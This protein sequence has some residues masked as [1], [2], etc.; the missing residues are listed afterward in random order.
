M[1][2]ESALERHSKKLANRERDLRRRASRPE[3]EILRSLSEL[4]QESLDSLASEAR[5]AIQI[6]VSAGLVESKVL[7][8]GNA[9]NVETLVRMGADAMDNGRTTVQDTAAE[10]LRQIL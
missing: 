4:R 5:E 9:D 1:I 7:G 8:L 6:L 10:I 2:L 3:H